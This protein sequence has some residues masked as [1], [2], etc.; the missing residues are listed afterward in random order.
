MSPGQE[1]HLEDMPTE[2]RSPVKSQDNVS[3][4]DNWEKNLQHWVEMA[5]RNGE[6]AILDTLLPRFEQIVIKAA[7]KYTKGHRQDAAKL[8]GWGRNTL[9]RKMKELKSETTYE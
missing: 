7:L 9:T 5:L 6:K 1:I 8:L 4:E 3:N 2:L